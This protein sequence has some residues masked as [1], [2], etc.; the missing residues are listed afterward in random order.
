MTGPDRRRIN[1]QQL[2]WGLVPFSGI[3]LGGTVHS[4]LPRPT[5]SDFR[6]SHP[7]AGFLPPKPSGPISCRYRSWG[8]PS[9]PFPL[10]EP[11]N[12]FG[13]GDLH[14]VRLNRTPQASSKRTGSALA[15]KAL[16]STRIRHLRRGGEPSRK[17]GALLVF[18]PLRV[19]PSLRPI[20]Y[21]KDPLMRLASNPGPKSQEADCASGF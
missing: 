5:P 21:A 2:S 18:R 7:L 12:P 16:L 13:I 17:A 4:G 10:A 8:F 14:D 19:S 1:Q 6:V 3:S 20:A 11:S 15:F 9:G